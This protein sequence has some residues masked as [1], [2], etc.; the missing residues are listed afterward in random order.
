[1]S[2]VIPFPQSEEKLLN[3]I[4]DAQRRNDF[5]AMYNLFQTYEQD[6]ELNEKVALKKCWMLLQMNSFLELR[7]EAII[8]LKRGLNCY[9]ELIIYYIKSL[10]G[11]GQY[12]EAVEVI[13]QIIEEV[14]NNKTR[15]ELFPLMEYA[16][17]RLDVDKQTL[18]TSLSQF[19]EL[20]NR[21]Q[22]SIVLQLIDNG[23]YQFKETIAH[24][25]TIYDVPKNIISLMLE[26]LRFAEYNQSLMIKKYNIKISVVPT[27]LSGLEHTKMK[28]HVI[29]NVVNR[30]EEGALHIINEAHHIMNNH[31]ILLYPLQIETLYNL[32]DWIDAYDVYFKNLIGIENNVNNINTLEFIKLLDSKN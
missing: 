31:S 5:N 18:A 4:N 8:L 24:L 22:T 3:Q 30:L 32:E 23:H 21:E 13:N 9:D 20:S 15:M 11:L 26:F 1:M 2:N 19:D 12:Y 25:L 17:S 6:F 10:N 27:Q 14:R 28:E 29:P 16:K 7:E